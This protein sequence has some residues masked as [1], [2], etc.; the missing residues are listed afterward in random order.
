MPFFSCWP[1]C[2]RRNR[3]LCS[4][5]CS[6]SFVDIVA[7]TPSYIALVNRDGWI[8][9]HNQFFLMLRIMRLFKLSNYF[10]AMNLLRDVIWSRRHALEV[11][12]LVSAIITIVFACLLYTAERHDNTHKIDNMSS[13]ACGN[14]CHQAD[15]FH[16]A[17]AAIQPAVIHL[18]GDYPIIDYTWPGRLCCMVAVFVG[19]ALCTWHW[20]LRNTHRHPLRLLW[21]CSRTKGLLDP[22]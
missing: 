18:T 17:F 4:W 14:D 5:H 7:L 19:V 3:N 21:Q 16:N 9:Q 12:G 13:L 1:G 8:A 22:Q 15:R 20:H 10:P 2:H 11:S 6:S